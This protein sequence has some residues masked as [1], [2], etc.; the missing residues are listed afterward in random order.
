MLVCEIR[1]RPITCVFCGDL[2]LSQCF[3]VFD[4]KTGLKEGEVW[5]KSF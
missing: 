1:D 3:L 2:H 5:R 4:K